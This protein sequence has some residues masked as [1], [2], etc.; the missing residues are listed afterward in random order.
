MER[1]N[2]MSEKYD[3]IVVGGGL[4]GLSAAATLAKNGQR[5]LLLE[6]HYRPGGYAGSFVR[7]RF[8]FEIALH[9][10]SGLNLEDKRGFLYRSLENLGITKRVDFIRLPT[11]YRSVFPDLDL[12]LPVGRESAEG[13]LV[14]T[15]PHDSDGIKRFLDR[16]D[17][18]NQ[19][20]SALQ[21]GATSEKEKGEIKENFFAYKDATLAEVLNK[22]INDHRARAVIAQ[23]FAYFGLPPSKVSYLIY[24]LGWGDYL[25]HGGAQ[26]RGTSQTLCNAFVDI[27]QE[28]GS[29]VRFSCGVKKILTE[30][31]RVTG[32]VTDKDEKID[33]NYIISNVNP[34]T[35]CAEMIGVDKCP[36]TIFQ[37][38]NTKEM[39]I[40][41]ICVYMGLDVPHE[42]LGIDDFEIFL[43][44][45]YDFDSLWE[46]SRTGIE[47]QDCGLGIYNVAYT[48]A[49]PPGT[50][51][52]VLTTISYA[53][54]WYKVPPSKYVETKNRVADIMLTKAEKFAPG[55]RE[56]IEVV[57]VSTPLTNMRYTGN[58]GGSIYGWPYAP[59]ES[60]MYRLPQEGPLKGLYFAGAWTQIGGGYQPCIM[61]GMMAAQKVMADITK[62]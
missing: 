58:P 27:V 30:G 18:T 48:D 21:R 32:V 39:A 1:E 20:L 44:S 45:G 6:K 23:V 59:K 38:M 37:T 53:E 42:E 57:E 5:V 46:K 25:R 40:G 10:I 28:M 35:T 60:L 33:S 41:T 34:M 14:D 17:A 56:H 61:S 15:F 62:K 3:A 36:S 22:D 29:D 7:G 51:M 52:A 55:I 11:V 13:V 26:V 2:E 16:L 8:E 9:Q 31:G 19:A 43:N 4:G 49:S 24:A 54:P 47:P 50:T 12:T